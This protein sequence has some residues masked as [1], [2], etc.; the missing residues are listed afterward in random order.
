MTLEDNASIDKPIT[1]YLVRY[2]PK[3]DRIKMAKTSPEG[4]LLDTACILNM[5]ALQLEDKQAARREAER[6]AKT[7]LRILGTAGG[8]PEKF[9][10]YSVVYNIPREEAKLM[11]RRNADV[12]TYDGRP[13][14]SSPRSAEFARKYIIGDVNPPPSE[15]AFNWWCKRFSRL[16]ISSFSMGSMVG[17]EVLNKCNE[18]LQEKGFTQKQASQI[19]SHVKFISAAD[20]SDVGFFQSGATIYRVLN[21]KDMII[22]VFSDNLETA[23]NWAKDALNTNGNGKP[24]LRKPSDTYKDVLIL[25]SAYYPNQHLVYV[26][27]GEWLRPGES[28]ENVKNKL[29]P[30]TGFYKASM[31]G[32][33]YEP[34]NGSGK[35]GFHIDREDVPRHKSSTYYRHALGA[36]GFLVPA[37]VQNLYYNAVNHMLQAE[38]TGISLPVP[39]IEKMVMPPD[40]LLFTPDITEN[41]GLWKEAQLL[42]DVDHDGASSYR[43]RVS[44]GIH[45]VHQRS[46]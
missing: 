37:L 15:D 26:D 29:D 40:R 36:H 31:K 18:L 2:N 45:Y 46:S 4:T 19:L 12:R 43:E 17:G 27:R 3:G 28:E 33:F 16:V 7:S 42:A 34:P 44:R 25:T 11:A 30:S 21:K 13:M 32:N 10:T 9:R 41:R 14:P 24:H 23:D 8:V 38:A 5:G 35:S 20:V 22:P 1:P 6:A 39:S